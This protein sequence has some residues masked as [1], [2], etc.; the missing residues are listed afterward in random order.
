MMTTT[1]DNLHRAL[2]LVAV[3]MDSSQWIPRGHHSWCGDGRCMALLFL[4][5]ALVLLVLVLGF[6]L[7]AV[8]GEVVVW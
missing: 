3:I 8:V 6:F 1:T 4:L 2:E 7:L 5:L